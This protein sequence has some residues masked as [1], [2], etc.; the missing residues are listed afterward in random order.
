MMSGRLNHLQLHDI[1]EE[2]SFFWH[3]TLN[4]CTRML[5]QM[6]HG[7]NEAIVV[8][9]RTAGCEMK[10]SPMSVWYL[11]YQLSSEDPQFILAKKNQG[12][13]SAQMKAFLKL[14]ELMVHADRLER[15]LAIAMF[16]EKVFKRMDLLNSGEVSQPVFMAHFNE[17]LRDVIIVQDKLPNVMLQGQASQAAPSSSA[18]AAPHPTPLAPGLV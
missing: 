13:L 2:Y 10:Q 18:A 8:A 6:V 3:L 9:R 17:V 4:G 16:P 1:W 15:K 7:I 14:S 5:Q 11:D 12:K